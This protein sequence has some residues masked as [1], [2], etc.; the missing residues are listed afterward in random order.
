MTIENSF[1]RIANAL[2]H[3]ESLLK[4]G[5]APQADTVEQPEPAPKAPKKA[6]AAKKKEAKS[7]DNA[8][9]K[10]PVSLDEFREELK[11]VARVT[12][13]DAVRDLITK[14]NATTVSDVAPEDRAAMLDDAAVLA[15]A[16]S[17]EAAI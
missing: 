10:A 14:Y 9:A 8:M 3:I 5:S 6:P 17:A 2:E 16:I 11:A 13:I 15:N 12:G 1:E 7:A 4:N